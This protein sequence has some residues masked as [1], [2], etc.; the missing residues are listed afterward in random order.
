M[1]KKEYSTV[2]KYWVLFVIV[3]SILVSYIYRYT[4]YICSRYASFYGYRMNRQ[5]PELYNA[6]ED[7]LNNQATDDDGYRYSTFRY[8]KFYYRIMRIGWLLKFGW[9]TKF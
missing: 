2:G 9:E 3:F 7:K 1:K 8:P 4:P 6:I 5:F